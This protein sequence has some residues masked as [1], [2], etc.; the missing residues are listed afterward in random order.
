MRRRERESWAIAENLRPQV[1]VSME[2]VWREA[3]AKLGLVEAA[4][5]A[6]RE[7]TDRKGQVP[8][9]ADVVGDMDTDDSDSART[10]QDSAD[11]KEVPQVS[12]D[13]WVRVWFGATAVAHYRAEKELAERYVADV[14][15]HFRGLWFTI[16]PLPDDAPPTRPLPAERLW[17]LAP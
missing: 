7:E 9:I 3:Y 5:Q 17:M 10:D 16:D 14:G 6:A 15:R 1:V 4:E 11:A 13:V 8:H 2:A 12:G